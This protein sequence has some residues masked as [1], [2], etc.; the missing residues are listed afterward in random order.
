[1]AAIESGV[2]V[3]VTFKKPQAPESKANNAVTC[4][5]CGWKHTYSRHDAAKRGWEAHKKACKAY[6]IATLTPPQWLKDQTEGKEL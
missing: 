1:M 5:H 4:P 6:Q 2:E 3:T